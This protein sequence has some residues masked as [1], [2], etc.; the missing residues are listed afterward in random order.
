MADETYT[1]KQAV[2]PFETDEVKLSREAELEDVVKQILE[3]IR[4]IEWNFLDLHAEDPNILLRELL[5]ITQQTV[6]LTSSLTA[7]PLP[8]ELPVDETIKQT[9]TVLVTKRQLEVLREL[10]TGSSITEI[11]QAFSIMEKTVKEHLTNIYRRLG[12][13]NRAEAV[14]ISRETVFEVNENKRYFK[15]NS[16]T[17][18]VILTNREVAVLKLLQTGLS[19]EDI[20]QALLIKVHTVKF[21]LSNIYRKTGATNRTEAAVFYVE[22]GIDTDYDTQDRE[23][24]LRRLLSHASVLIAEAAKEHGVLELL[25][26]ASRK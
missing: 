23:Q 21:H 14:R 7:P 25:Q 17:D 26:R 2:A 20:A 18:L 15:G 8:E 11:S 5:P 12:V 1:G 13:T 24:K 10:E 3:R 19:N 16:N 4:E 9:N 22:R 6:R